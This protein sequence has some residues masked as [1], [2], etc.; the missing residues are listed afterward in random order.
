MAQLNH[1]LVRL[2][3]ELTRYAKRNPAHCRSCQGMPLV[4]FED[5]LANLW[6]YGADGRC[7][8]CGATPPSRSTVS[9][10][11][12]RC[13]ELFAGMPFSPDPLFG[14]L[15]RILLFKAVATRDWRAAE[16][17]VQRVCERHTGGRP[18]RR[19]EHQAPRAAACLS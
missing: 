18:L 8:R 15:E 11:R 3:R 4:V 14:K 1:K 13:T 2:E 10:A 12:L 17:V 9:L 16:H 19:M 7:A 6:P 5:D